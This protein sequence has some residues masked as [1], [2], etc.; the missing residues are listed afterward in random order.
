[1]DEEYHGGGLLG[2]VL[3]FILGSLLVLL[4]LSLTRRHRSIILERD[5]EG[6]VVG[7]HYV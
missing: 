7:I 5:M 1:M 3:G 6:R 4:I 2:F